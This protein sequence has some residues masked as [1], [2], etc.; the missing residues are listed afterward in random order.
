MPTMLAC[1]PWE[2]SWYQIELT[3]VGQRV[4]PKSTRFRL[5]TPCSFLRNP[6]IL[7]LV[8]GA[9]LLLSRLRRRR[10]AKHTVC[11][12][13]ERVHVYLFLWVRHGSLLLGCR[14][15]HQPGQ[16]ICDC[17]LD[18][19][20]SSRYGKVCTHFASELKPCPARIRSRYLVL[21]GVQNGG[22]VMLGNYIPK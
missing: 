22:A 15:P 14:S 1:S 13:I 9:F 17:L 18:L 20:L 21:S 16:S 10:I 3:L 19:L 11:Y 6:W 5:G 7:H 8:L 12:G 2:K 4:A